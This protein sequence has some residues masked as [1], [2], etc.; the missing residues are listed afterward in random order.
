MADWTNLPNTAVGVGGL[1]SGTTVTALRDNP[2]AIAE[3]AAGAPVVRGGW[4]SWNGTT[5]GPSALIYDAAV[6]GNVT[7]IETPVLDESYEY[8]LDIQ[9]LSR[10]DTEVGN[11]L[12][13]DLFLSQTGAYTITPNTKIGTLSSFTRSF[14]TTGSV[15]LNTQ[16]NNQNVHV[17]QIIT[18][19]K[20]D[21]ANETA[22]DYAT[23]LPTYISFGRTS[24]TKITR[25]RL[26]AGVT[27]G[28]RAGRVYLFRR[29]LEGA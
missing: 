5:Y 10:N 19:D 16:K 2:V 25:M 8:R 4:H 29:K 24:A 21:N 1:P 28:I 12:L 6:D 26:R 20:A 9:D 7:S 22:P 14:R 11:D 13:L 15:I 17:V 18:G 23:A 3:G 27:N